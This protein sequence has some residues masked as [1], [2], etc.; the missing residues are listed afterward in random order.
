[1]QNAPET[2]T[3]HKS[4]MAYYGWLDQRHGIFLQAEGQVSFL[5][6]ATQLWEEVDLPTL[7]R[8]ATL[9]GRVD[10]A[11]LQLAKDGDRVKACS[12]T[13]QAA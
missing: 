10:I 8:W 4:A 1:M 6:S 11:D 3:P 12:R 9:N 13:L 5:D 2:T 7:T